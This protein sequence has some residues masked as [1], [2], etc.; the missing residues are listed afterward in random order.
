MVVCVC[1]LSA[2]AGLVNGAVPWCLAPLDPWNISIHGNGAMEQWSN[3]ATTAI[4]IVLQSSGERKREK[5]RKRER[6]HQRSLF[7]HSLE[8]RTDRR[9]DSG[10]LQRPNS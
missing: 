9:L 2:L 6:A 8:N 1:G 7:G 5:E 4:S 3:G 10:Q